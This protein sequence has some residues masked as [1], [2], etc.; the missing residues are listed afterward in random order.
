MYA[1]QEFSPSLQYTVHEP[2][3]FVPHV[4]QS[5]LLAEA[6]QTAGDRE[7]LTVLLVYGRETLS[8]RWTCVVKGVDCCIFPMAGFFGISKIDN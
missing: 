5:V 2:R 7:E 1:R 6:L 8:A 4:V 3:C